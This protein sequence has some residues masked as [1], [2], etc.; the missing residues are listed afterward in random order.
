MQREMDAHTYEDAL[1]DEFKDTYKHLLTH[2]RDRG[3]MPL[4]SRPKPKPLGLNSQ[5]HTRYYDLDQQQK[6]LHPCLLGPYGLVGNTQ[7]ER[8]SETS[9]MSGTQRHNNA[10]RVHGISLATD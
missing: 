3:R 10:A 7:Q 4:T 1:K 6:P 5:T 9:G 2:G 8:G